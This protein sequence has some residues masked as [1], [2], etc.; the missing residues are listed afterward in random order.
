MEQL[1]GPPVENLC[2]TGYTDRRVH[3]HVHLSVDMFM[4]TVIIYSGG[5]LCME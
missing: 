2:F 1:H 4:Y 5:T 3:V